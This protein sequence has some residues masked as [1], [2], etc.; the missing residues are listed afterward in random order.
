MDVTVGFITSDP[1][2]ASH[3]AAAASGLGVQCLPAVS[4]PEGYLRSLRELEG[5]GCNAV[6][7]PSHVVPAL[8]GHS[9]LP[10]VPLSPGPYDV[11]RALGEART[12]GDHIALLHF[13]PG[14]LPVQLFRE[15]VGTSIIEITPGRS[16]DQILSALRDSR[17][18]GLQVVVSGQ[19]VASLASWTGLKAVEIRV[20]PEALADAVARAAEMGRVTRRLSS[21]LQRLSEAFPDPEPRALTPDLV[22]ESPAMKE[23]KSRLV[24]VATREEPVLFLGEAGTGRQFWARQVHLARGRK[25]A[26]FI[27]LECLSLACGEAEEAL[28]R[29]LALAKGGTLFLSNVA[30]LPRDTQRRVRGLLDVVPHNAQGEGILLCASACVRGPGDEAGLLGA[31]PLSVQVPPLRQ[32]IEDIEP[33]FCAFVRELAPT[34]GEL[35]RFFDVGFLSDAGWSRLK[36]HDWPGNVRELRNL[37]VRYVTLAR[38]TP[39]RSLDEV[40]REV[41]NGL[42]KAGASPGYVKVPVGPLED[43]VDEILRKTL[44]SAGGNRSEVAR[45]LS[46]SRTTLWKR[47]KKRGDVTTHGS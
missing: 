34:P 25:A 31:F 14:A 26:S 8:Q 24:A 38:A 33:L 37:A 47:L 5:S 20:G 9:R 1:D 19:G 36:S 29:A 12:L 39:P 10:V 6:V 4:P 13:G 11:L 40:E 17:A 32:R 27:S 7:A 42:Q 3:C 28:S 43:M 30:S 22:T 15:L 18:K 2:L 46:I 23:V 44:A 41:L 35:G 16:R 45:R 21:R